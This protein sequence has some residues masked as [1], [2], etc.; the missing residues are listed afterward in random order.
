MDLLEWA[1]PCDVN[2][3]GL[4]KYWD[5][6]TARAMTWK[7]MKK[8]AMMHGP[9]IWSRSPY[10][11]KCSEVPEAGRLLRPALG[12]KASEWSSAAVDWGPNFTSLSAEQNEIES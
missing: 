8:L 2:D 12:V 3:F 4:A 10:I 9:S 5:L 1:A 11:S 7:A 6:T